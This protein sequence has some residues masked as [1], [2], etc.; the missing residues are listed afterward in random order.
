MSKINRLRL[1]AAI[2]VA[3]ESV[4]IGQSVAE[5]NYIERERANDSNGALTPPAISSVT[6]NSTTTTWPCD[7]TVVGI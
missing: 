5:E 1:D 7:Q 3:P 6:A 2:N 4:C